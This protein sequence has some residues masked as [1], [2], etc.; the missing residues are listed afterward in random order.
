HIARLCLPDATLEIVFSYD[1]QRD[2]RPGAPLGATG[3]DEAHITTTL[4]SL[5]QQAGLRI[6]AVEEISQHELA[7]YHTTWAK[8]LAYGPLRRV[9][10]IQARRVGEMART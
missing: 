3:F 4:P 5:Y 7:A 10:K 8:R 1:R 6:V 9:W 2:A